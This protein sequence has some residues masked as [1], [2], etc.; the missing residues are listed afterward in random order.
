MVIIPKITASIGGKLTSIGTA[1]PGRRIMA[2]AKPGRVVYVPRQAIPLLARANIVPP[3]REGDLLDIR[4]VD[5][6][7]LA[8]DLTLTE[9]MECKTH[10]RNAGLLDPGR[11]IRR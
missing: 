2:A 11:L 8:S 1:A 4:T 7:L 10:L 6:Q 5:R 9:K 3:E